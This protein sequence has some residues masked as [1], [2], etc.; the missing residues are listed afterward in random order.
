MAGIEVFATGGI[1]GVHRGHPSDIS[2]D[3]WEL[4]QTPV[5]VVSAG[6]KAILDLPLTLEWLETRGVPVLGYRTDTLPAF[7]TRSSGLIVD[8]RVNTP[9][10]VVAIWHAKRSLGLQGG[11]LV[12]VPIPIQDAMLP[13]VVS[14]AIHA[15]LQEAEAQGVRGRE[16]TPHLLDHIKEH[17][18]G[19]SVEANIALL[20]NNAAVAAK[21]AIATN[22]ELGKP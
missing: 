1:G 16:L 9:Q 5:I 15:A 4:A 8:A 7:Y 6:A 17:T 11:L 10:E 20:K 21:I 22:Q 18:G 14:S 12:A 13:Q 2:A 3:L 19:Q